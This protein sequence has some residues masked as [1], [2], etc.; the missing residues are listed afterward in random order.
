MTPRFSV[1]IAVWNGAATIG[2]AIESVTAQ[3]WPAHELIV[4]DDGSTDA[5]PGVLARF[6]SRLRRVRQENAGAAAARNAGAR[7]ATGDWLAFLD[8]DDVYYPE[9][10]RRH[11][12]WIARDASLDFL[13]GDQEYRG[14]DG[15]LLRRSMESTA[16]GRALLARAAGQREVVMA[17]EDLAAFVEDHFGDT[18]TLSV[19]T[20]R[21]L[22]VG[23]Y[24]VGYP[25]CEDVSLLIR[26]CARAQRVGVVC[27][28][29]AVY[30][31]HPQ[32][33][34][35]RDPLRAQRSTVAALT[36]LGPEL[37]AAPEPVRRGWRG[38]L[39]RARL[40]LAYALLREGSRFGALQAV[41]PNLTGGPGLAGVRDLASV[42]RGALGPPARGA[43]A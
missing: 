4:V 20:E 12:E 3:T 29:L 42:L 40:D 17:G 7:L 43:G 10:L 25:V 35:R 39:R 36:A 32:S 41:T 24:P 15:T 33:A 23:G 11:A 27:E 38:A 5:T 6:G 22:A 30:N 34:T 2:R 31:V 37:A 9:R 28:P 14:P 8:A 18:H 19:P 26:L 1:V 16:A 13:T 21:F